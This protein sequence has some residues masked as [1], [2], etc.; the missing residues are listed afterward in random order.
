MPKR[1]VRILK[2]TKIVWRGYQLLMQCKRL[3]S[4]PSETLLNYNAMCNRYSPLVIFAYYLDIMYIFYV[5]EWIFS[6][7][8][9]VYKMRFPPR[10]SVLWRVRSLSVSMQ[11]KHKQQPCFA[12][13]VHLRRRPT[14]NKRST[15]RHF[16]TKPA[17]NATRK[18][19][20]A[21]TLHFGHEN[22]PSPSRFDKIVYF[23]SLFI[24]PN[25]CD[26]VALP[27]GGA[28]E[29]QQVPPP[30]QRLPRQLSNV[31]FMHWT[32]ERDGG[33]K[34]NRRAWALKIWLQKP[35]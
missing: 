33:V 34:G 35:T 14:Q 23:F 2:I 16:A 28:R 32:R 3:W 12:A 1:K 19:F 30:S 7:S 17:E 10:A 6:C 18:C 5:L 15:Y 8:D 4:H 29:S 25:G 27:P 13:L 22:K 31:S 20:S 26:G 9:T 24:V 11:L 21:P